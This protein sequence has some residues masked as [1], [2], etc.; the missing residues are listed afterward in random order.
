M[1]I[2]VLASQGAFAEHIAILRRLKVE[3]VPVRL[4]KDLEGLDGLIIPGGE[5]TTIAKLMRD[6]NLIDVIKKLAKKGLPIFGTC[7]GMVLLGEM[8]EGCYPEP[9]DLMHISVK[10][11]AFGRQRE[12][13]ETDLIIPALGKEPFHCVFIRAPSISRA[14]SEVEVITQLP[15]GTI[16]AAREGKLLVAAFHPELTDDLRFH[17]Y[18]IDMIKEGKK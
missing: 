1:K 2:G 7:A 10:R 11:N 9:L 12:S 6:Y 16:V 13:F 5:S 3:A 14:G 17:G 4:P 18:F 15:D 8:E